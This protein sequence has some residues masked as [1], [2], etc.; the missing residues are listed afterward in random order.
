MVKE[1]VGQHIADLDP[2][3]KVRTS[4][5]FET[6]ATAAKLARRGAFFIAVYNTPASRDRLI[7]DLR[8]RVDPLPLFIHAL[9]AE[10]YDPLEYLTALTEQQREQQAVICF[11]DLEE[12]WPDGARSLDRLR[13]SLARY[14][15]AL[16][17]WLQQRP[18]SNLSSTAPHFF[19]RNSGVFDLRLVGRDITGSGS[20]NG[21]RPFDSA[22]E[23][24]RSA[25]TRKHP[26]ELR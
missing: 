17:L 6:L 3:E 23:R 8:R 14:P 2:V 24:T 18:Y 10:D 25:S 21:L 11:I 9:S 20:A 12:A 16:I 19:S 13:D 4:L 1:M 7:D 5:E 26:F 15:H 22:V